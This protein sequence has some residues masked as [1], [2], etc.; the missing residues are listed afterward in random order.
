[1]KKFYLQISNTIVSCKKNQFMEIITTIISTITFVSAFFWGLYNFYLKE[2]IKNA[3]KSEFIKKEKELIS[4][5]NLWRDLMLIKKEYYIHLNLL[6]MDGSHI[7]ENY[8]KYNRN[9]DH[10]NN[11]KKYQ[12]IY[13]FYRNLNYEINNKLDVNKIYIKDEIYKKSIFYIELI[14]EMN[15]INTLVNNELATIKAGGDIEV[16]INKYSEYSIYKNKNTFEILD[17]IEIDVFNL[18]QEYIKNN[19]EVKPIKFIKSVNK[20]FMKIEYNNNNNNNNNKNEN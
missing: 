5:E 6:N 3:V 15:L 20:D 8:N 12:K 17:S 4:L 1:M 19:F 13:N 10:K 14:L 16:V 18:I 9:N 7:E 2:N 11:A